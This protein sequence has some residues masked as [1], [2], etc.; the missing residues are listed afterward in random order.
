MAPPS[1]TDPEQCQSA[2][3]DNRTKE[4]LGGYPNNYTP[5]VRH[6]PETSRCAPPRPTKFVEA[7]FLLLWRRRLR[8]ATLMVYTSDKYMGY[9]KYTLDCIARATGNTP[10]P[11]APWTRSTVPFA[12][13]RIWRCV[14]VGTMEPS[15][16]LSIA[17]AGLTPVG[18]GWGFRLS[19][20]ALSE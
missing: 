9:F 1:S 10:A 19:P 20:S 15:S 18:K 13:A 2:S 6:A 4:K 5:R 11:E 14:R 8:R 3:L 16:Y 7:S 12:L 17:Q